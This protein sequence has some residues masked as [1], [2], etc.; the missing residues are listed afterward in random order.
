MN[1][2]TAQK[3]AKWWGE[4]LHGTVKLDN[5]D[6]SETGAMTFVLASMLQGIEKGKQSEVDIT[7]FEKELATIL[8]NDKRQWVTV[9]V[10][11]NPDY[12]LSEAAKKAHCNLGMTS[13]PWK[14][15]MW[16]HDEEIKVAVGYG[17]EPQVLP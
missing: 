3:A 15:M 12:I 10:D 5:G 1:K 16:I 2:D 6:N 4:Q 17:A 13:L 11:Y 14:T 8:L 7:N 9:G